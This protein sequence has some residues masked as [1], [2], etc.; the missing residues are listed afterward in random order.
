MDSN[1][2]INNLSDLPTPVVLIA[3]TGECLTSNP[4]AKRLVS[5]LNLADC[6]DLL[7]EVLFGKILNTSDDL[8]GVYD[9]TLYS[10]A[11]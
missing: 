4:A 6:S 10:N 8:I 9:D 5:A 1:S 3:K 7:P 2:L 11:E